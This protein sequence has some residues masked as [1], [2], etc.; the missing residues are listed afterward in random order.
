M[1]NDLLFGVPQQQNRFQLAGTNPTFMDQFK[2][3]YGE[4]QPLL[5][6][7]PESDRGFA[8]MYGLQSANQAYQSSPQRIKEQLETM[9]PFLKEMAD[10]KEKQAI[11]ANLFGSILK[12]IPAAIKNYAYA[13]REYNPTLIEIAGRSRIP[14]Y[15][16]PVPT[17]SPRNYFGFVR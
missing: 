12:D 17:A 11:T 7:I 14:D 15:I 1:G 2:N 8:L 4:M 13:G 16:P 10:Y 5:Q 9:R 6:S 3:V